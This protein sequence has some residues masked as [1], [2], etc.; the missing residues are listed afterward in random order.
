MDSRTASSNSMGPGMSS[1]GWAF[2]VDIFFGTTGSVVFAGAE[3]SV[4]VGACTYGCACACACAGAGARGS[5]FLSCGFC[6]LMVFPLSSSS[7]EPRSVENGVF[8]SR[9]GLLSKC[10]AIC[11]TRAPAAARDVGAMRGKGR[12]FTEVERSR[13]PPR[14]HIRCSE[15]CEGCDLCRVQRDT[16]RGD[17][18]GIGGQLRMSA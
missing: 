8:N 15:V 9:N 2:W 18:E 14:F 17:C 7:R 5:G 12:L 4:G 3:V 16:C 11:F 13:W 6:R 10:L 1:A